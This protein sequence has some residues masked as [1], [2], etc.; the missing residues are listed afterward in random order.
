MVVYSII[1]AEPG[2]YWGPGGRAPRRRSAGR[3]SPF[4][5]SSHEGFRGTQITTVVHV[6]QLGDELPV[7]Y[8]LMY[9]DIA[10]K[11]R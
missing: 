7:M 1:L 2:I 11:Y 10:V 3:L 9:D 5:S 4:V 6:G 8:V